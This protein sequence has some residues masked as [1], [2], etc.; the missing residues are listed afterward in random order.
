[1]RR[2]IAIF[3]STALAL[4]VMLPATAQVPAD[5]ATGGVK[6]AFLVDPTNERQL[7]FTA[8]D[9]A[10]GPRGK[11]RWEI[12]T[13]PNSGDMFRGT[14]NRCYSELAENEA[15]FSGEI[16]KGTGVFANRTDFKVQVQDNQPGG[17]GLTPDEFQVRVVGPF[18]CD[19][20]DSL[21]RTV[22]EGNLTV[23]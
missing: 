2:K 16:D 12:L 3:A 18:N 11:V 23:H 7:D 21:D 15:V 9:H 20:F 8:Q 17:S 19:P 5:K 10:L 4:A 6:G 13:G 1:M 22:T 14:V